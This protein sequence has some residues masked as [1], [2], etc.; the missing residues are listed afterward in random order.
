[1]AVV[2]NVIST[3][4]DRGLKSATN[5]LDKF[6]K[7]TTEKL[8][9]TTKAMGAVGFGI[10]AGAGAVAVGLYQIGSSFDEAFDAIRT[11]TGATGPVLDQLKNDMKAVAT[12]F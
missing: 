9:S 11:G 2:L 6:S 3:F 5:E 1:M 4:N 8:G 7:A 10:L 12:T